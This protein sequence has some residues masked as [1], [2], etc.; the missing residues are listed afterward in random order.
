MKTK[1]KAPPTTIN[2]ARI[3]VNWNSPTVVNADSPGP[4]DL[5]WL[6]GALAVNACILSGSDLPLA[7]ELEMV[8]M[9]PVP[10][11]SPV[12]VKAGPLRFVVLATT[13]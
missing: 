11:L 1:I 10:G 2:T 9:Y 5:R 13:N 4:P 8:T 12:T 7:F 6:T 3:G